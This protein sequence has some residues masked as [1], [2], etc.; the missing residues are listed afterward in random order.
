M[1]YVLNFKIINMN[2][3]IQL[4]KN[5]L[6]ITS[7]SAIFDNDAHKIVSKEGERELSKLSSPNFKILDIS[8]TNKKS[9]GIK[10]ETLSADHK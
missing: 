3:F 5:T 6:A 4:L 8:A 9:A 7:L 1:R 10:C 2:K